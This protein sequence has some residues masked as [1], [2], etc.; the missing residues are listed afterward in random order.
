MVTVIC[1][2]L[3]TPLIGTRFELLRLKNVTLASHITV[4]FDHY[5]DQGGYF[6]LCCRSYNI[7]L[8]VYEYAHTVRGEI[9]IP[10][11]LIISNRLD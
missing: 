10:V 11:V 9:P 2:Y 4:M 8:I 3:Y 7:S 5:S 1:R 6:F